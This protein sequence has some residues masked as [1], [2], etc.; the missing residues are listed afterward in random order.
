MGTVACMT[1]VAGMAA[2]ARKLRIS[3]VVVWPFKRQRVWPSSWMLAQTYAIR[4]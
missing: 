2:M 4:H 3:I 1:S